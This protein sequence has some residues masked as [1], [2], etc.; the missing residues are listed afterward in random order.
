MHSASNGVAKLHFGAL[1]RRRTCP[2]TA[3]TVDVHG[4]Q[5]LDATLKTGF[6]AAAEARVSRRR[7]DTSRWPPGQ[8]LLKSR[9][10]SASFTVGGF[11]LEGYP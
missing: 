1:S 5:I 6:G 2:T 8:G 7:A 10:A 11:Q 9:V 4:L 3:G